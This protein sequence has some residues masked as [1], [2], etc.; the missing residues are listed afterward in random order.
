MNN[1][2]RSILEI[3]NG[4]N[5]YILIRR[6]I[7]K[8][9][10]WGYMD[11]SGREV[12]PC[13]YRSAEPFSD[14]LAYACDGANEYFIDESGE[15]A[16]ELDERYEYGQFE[17]GRCEIRPWGEERHGYVNKKGELISPIVDDEP[18]FPEGLQVHDYYMGDSPCEWVNEKGDV[19]IV[20]RDLDFYNGWD[21]RDR[22]ASA[23][24]TKYGRYGFLD[25][26][27]QVVIPFIFTNVLPWANGMAPVS[28]D[29]KWGFIDMDM[30]LLI[31]CEYHYGLL[32]HPYFD[33]DGILLV[34]RSFN[35][36]ED[37]GE[38][39]DFLYGAIDRCG[40]EIVPVDYDGIAKIDGKIAVLV[41]LEDEDGN[42]YM[43]VKWFDVEKQ[44]GNGYVYQFDCEGLSL[45]K[46]ATLE[47][48]LLRWGFLDA[49]GAE[50]IPC[51]YDDA[52]VRN[53]LIRVRKNGLWAFVK[54]S[55]EFLTPFLYQS[56]FSPVAGGMCAVQREGLWGFINEEGEEMVPC[57]YDAVTDFVEG[58]SMVLLE[59]R[60]GFIAADGREVTP[61]IYDMARPFSGGLAWV[62]K[63]AGVGSIN[64]DGEEV[65]PCRFDRVGKGSEG[66]VSVCLTSKK[67][68]HYMFLDL[69]GNTVI[70]LD[71][72]DLDAVSIFSEGLCGICKNFEW[73]F[74]DRSGKVV[75]PMTFHQPYFNLQVQF[76]HGLCLFRSPENWGL[77]AINTRGEVVIP[78]AYRRI[79]WQEDGRWAAR[80][81]EETHYYNN[82]GERL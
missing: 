68:E 39:T 70:D 55:G 27:G 1:P 45:R 12:I 18:C 54:P 26:R 75:I 66:L 14:G 50:V 78:A 3:R 69:D 77:G 4:G 15:I 6:R 9:I 5:K 51:T 60:Y 80:V 29:G 34:S 67:T 37:T 25:Q 16:F 35:K 48:G 23:S 57:R 64:K 72:M 61:L 32:S 7:G 81:G 56:A 52:M 79:D 24:H 44:E 53:G 59:E 47:G 8:D 13:R 46:V 76:I 33:E 2:E 41:N 21:F 43:G 63:G 82:D 17:N 30:N 36:D 22:L 42:W 19:V 20:A 11:G 65:I 58:R 71:G 74:I 10:L 62:R 31:P 73:G 40:R 28:I 49:E 38:P